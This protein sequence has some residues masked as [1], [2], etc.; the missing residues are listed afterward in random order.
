MTQRQALE[1]YV[2][3]LREVHELALAENS[4]LRANQPL[5]AAFLARKRA[6]G[7]RLDVA[8]QFLRDCTPAAPEDRELA[9]T[10]Q[11]QLQERLLQII[12]LDRENETLLLKTSLQRISIKTPAVPTA[13]R[14]TYAVS[15]LS[16]ADLHPSTTPQP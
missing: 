11:S 12:M 6:L 2:A 14:Q 15:P 16:G 4:R 3:L 8:L 7:A 5:D 9:R 10:L 13:V 1:N